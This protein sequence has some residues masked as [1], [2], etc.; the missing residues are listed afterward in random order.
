MLVPLRLAFQPDGGFET[1]WGEAA[2]KLNYCFAE[3]K[4][5]FRQEAEFSKRETP[6]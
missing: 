6:A 5:G 3:F 2:E 4:P 1:S